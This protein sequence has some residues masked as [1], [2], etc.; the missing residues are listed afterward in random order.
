[1]M[2]ELLRV[3]MNAKQIR[4]ACQQWAMTRATTEELVPAV[5]VEGIPDDLHVDCVF[6]K[7]RAPKKKAAAA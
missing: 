4:E 3:S 2:K 1:M 5:S 7:Q 6:S